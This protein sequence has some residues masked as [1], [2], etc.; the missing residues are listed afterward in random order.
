MCVYV[1]VFVWVCVCVCECISVYVYVF[2]CVLVGVF[3]N[4]E[5]CALYTYN[6]RY[7]KLDKAAAMLIVNN[8]AITSHW[9]RLAAGRVANGV[10]GEVF[11]KLGHLHDALVHNSGD[12]N[13][14]ISVSGELSLGA[15]VCTQR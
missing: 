1:C 9:T 14:L 11:R 12:E 15:I 7:T 8:M 5:L 10:P 3:I 13:N 6:G 4:S 2:V